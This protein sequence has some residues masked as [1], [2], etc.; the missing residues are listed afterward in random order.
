M[1]EASFHPQLTHSRVNAQ[2]KM[3]E[4]LV[5]E[6][7]SNYKPQ[8]GELSYQELYHKRQAYY[9]GVSAE[10]DRNALFGNFHTV[11]Q[12]YDLKSVENPDDSISLNMQ[13]N[14]GSQATKEQL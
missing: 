9:S 3:I 12:V 4:S 8:K 5:K 11:N 10:P 2:A 14:P 7:N 13:N 6:P 1:S